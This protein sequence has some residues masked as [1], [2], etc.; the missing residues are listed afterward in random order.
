MLLSFAM[1][2]ACDDNEDEGDTSGQPTKFMLSSFD[3][4]D[5]IATIYLY[6]AG[7]NDPSFYGRF[8]RN[9]DPQYISEGTG[10]YKV[11]IDGIATNNAQ[12][13]F[14]MKAGELNNGGKTDITDVVEFGITIFSLADYE[15]KLF[16]AAIDSANA[17]VYF[18][19][20]P[21]VPG[22]NVLKFEVPRKAMQS[23]GK[24]ITN[25]L[26]TFE[27]ISASKANPTI[28]YLDDF[29]ALTTDEEIVLSAAEKSLV[30]DINNMP[31]YDKNSADVRAKTEALMARY[32]ALPVED[33]PSI[34]NFDILKTNMDK[35]WSDDLNAAKVSEPNTLLFFD[36]TFGES[37]VSSHAAVVKSY[38]V[39]NAKVHGDDKA[40]LKLAL[41]TSSDS[42]NSF[43]T[44]TSGK[45]TGKFIEFW[46]YNDSNQYKGLKIDW[47]Y[48]SS[49][50]MLFEPNTWTKFV[51]PSED[52]TNRGLINFVGLADNKTTAQVPVGNLY[53]S[54]FVIR[55]MYT[56][57]E[58]IREETN[59]VFPF[60]TEYPASLQLTTGANY[61]NISNSDV[62]Y[63][64]D[65]KYGDQAG[66]TAIKLD[67]LNVSTVRGIL[68]YDTLGYEFQAGDMVVLQA[69]LDV[70]ATNART[71]EEVD[72]KTV[73][74]NN[75]TNYAE[76]EV[77]N[78]HVRLRMSGG[79]E[80]NY[81]HD[82][83]AGQW[84]TIVIGAEAFA[85]SYVEG[86]TEKDNRRFWFHPSIRMDATLY[87]SRAEVIPASEVVDITK[88]NA[89]YTLGGTTYIGSG[90]NLTGAQTPND[91][92]FQHESN[93]I[94]Y[95]FGGQIRFYV[96][97][98]KG[99]TP[100]PAVTLRY[101]TT[102]LANADKKVEVTLRGALVDQ[103]AIELIDT[104]G[105]ATKIDSTSKQAVDN[106]YT[107]YTC[108][109]ATGLGRISKIRIY[110]AGD[111]FSQDLGYRQI[112]LLNIEV[113]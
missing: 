48:P 2:V 8:E 10:S 101:K 51:V 111:E 47:T 90:E 98:Y 106:G 7:D 66:S 68:C 40:S 16:I 76:G 46:V 102:W 14:K 22:K 91:A 43:S 3:G 62:Y 53:F 9:K 52:Y 72:G 17:K 83:R 49:G 85:R 50:F 70:D 77:A 30:E 36:E 86:D 74:T 15:Y 78:A 75:V 82:I 26:I 97:N 5:D 65:V 113:K 69:Y 55:D 39:T 54:K 94:P 63:T 4:Y 56:E 99:A 44:Y 42:W 96:R 1:F 45:I 34:Y 79:T 95:Y 61:W 71:E 103:I 108:D 104:S 73:V 12:P 67:M 27:G 24:G 38:E 110:P 80:A 35:Y 88:S 20:Q 100:S 19:S 58:E 23:T 57:L 60:D 18:E 107:K 89:E 41:G 31:K 81:G 33:R 11:T 92:I 105:N 28:F 64:T 25:Y 109:I 87:L 84:T 29:Y 59:S 13:K 112:D 6:N 32:K 21:V 93:T 37:Q